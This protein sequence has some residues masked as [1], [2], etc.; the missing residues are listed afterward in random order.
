MYSRVFHHL[1]HKSYS[2]KF[3]MACYFNGHSLCGGGE[4]DTLQR[5]IIHPPLKSKGH[6]KSDSIR[7]LSCSL[8]K[9]RPKLLGPSHSWKSYKLIRCK[10]LPKTHLPRHR[11]VILR[12][13]HPSEGPSYFAPHITFLG[14]VVKTLVLCE[15]QDHTGPWGKR[16]NVHPLHM[17]LCI[18]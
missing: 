13:P 15:P 1:S 17:F 2:V 6:L 10:A 12:R 3:V 7:H 5:K 11:L 4:R 9:A 16:G 14:S 8:M 18:F